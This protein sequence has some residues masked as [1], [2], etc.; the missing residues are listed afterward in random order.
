MEELE[1]DSVFLKNNPKESEAHK[2]FEEI[3]KIQSGEEEILKTGFKPI[4]IFLPQGAGN[5]MIFIGSRPGHGKTH[6]CQVV[7]DG[8][9]NK[10]VNPTLNVEILRMNLEMPTKS[11]ILRELKKHLKMTTKEILSSSFDDM[12]VE[13]KKVVKKVYQ[14][15]N[16][17][18][19]TNFSESLEG[20]DLDYLITRFVESGDVLAKKVVLVDHLHIY[21]T[22][23]SIDD[24]LKICNKKKTLHPN[25]S[26]IFYFQFNRDLEELWR[27]SSKNKINP[28]NMFPHPGHIYGTDFLMQYADY[29][30]GIVIPQV[31]GLDEFAVVSKRGNEHL[32]RDFIP[33]KG[34]DFVTLK[35][36]NRVYYNAI[37]VRDREE[38]E[39]PS[40]YSDVLNP[41]YETDV[42]PVNDTTPRFDSEAEIDDEN[43]EPKF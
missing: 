21:A 41:K 32:Y 34:G 17:M 3:K 10:E 28:K 14:K 7:I 23:S 35:G 40:I 19:V 16:D 11:L 43:F 1:I 18:R 12:S 20:N 30:M 26:F 4:D 39:D 13:Q 6:N 29:V 38:F 8:L 24:V 33:G 5:K 25:L 31:V 9:L 15:F 27:E 2:A 42:N 37:K 22:K 36:R